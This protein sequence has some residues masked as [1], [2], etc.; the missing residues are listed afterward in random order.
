MTTSFKV[1]IGLLN[2]LFSF[3]AALISSLNPILALYSLISYV[4]GAF[5]V[6]A[7]TGWLAP[8]LVAKTN[9][10]Q[11]S[12]RRAVTYVAAGTLIAGSFVLGSG[13]FAHGANLPFLA[14]Q[15]A[16]LVLTAVYPILFIRLCLEGVAQFNAEHQSVEFA[17]G[18]KATTKINQFGSAKVFSLAAKVGAITALLSAIGIS[19]V[20][21]SFTQMLF[22]V[23]MVVEVAF[24]VGWT[25]TVLIAKLASRVLNRAKLPANRAEKTLVA[26]VF[27]VSGTLF[28]FTSGP[29][30]AFQKG[31]ATSIAVA[32][33]LTLSEALACGWL[34]KRF[35][36]M[37]SPL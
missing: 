19:T 2:G 3:V 6:A 7:L 9:A 25:A 15:I 37:N 21:T 17:T 16:I 5:L 31:E 22:M 30:I 32:V 18:P 20:A 33:A 26:T 4:F 34:T 36:L 24:I 35:L 11:S 28:I 12:N 13:I 8:Q 29:M 10:L 14:Q 27:L 1:K 23:V